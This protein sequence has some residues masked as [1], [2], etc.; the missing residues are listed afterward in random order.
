M[1]ICIK[2]LHQYLHMCAYVYALCSLKRNCFW[3]WPL[4]SDKPMYVQDVETYFFASLFP[5]FVTTYISMQHLAKVYLLKTGLWPPTSN[6][7][8]RYRNVFLASLFQKIFTTYIS[9]QHLAKVYLLKTG[10]WPPTSNKTTRYRNV[11]LASF[12]QKFVTTYI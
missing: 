7:T 10:L 3:T 6:K 9:M 11:F 8:A 12:F 2:S 1:Y 4:T 5:K